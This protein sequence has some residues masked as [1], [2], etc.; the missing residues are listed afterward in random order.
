[1]DVF[2]FISTE[3]HENQSQNLDLDTEKTD[4]LTSSD[5]VPREFSTLS[6]ND[7]DTEKNTINE[8][9]PGCFEGPEKT[10]EVVFRSGFGAEE[11][12][13]CFTKEQL[14]QL[15]Y[16]AKCNIL[17]KISNSHMDAYV[18]SE[19]SLFVYK[20]RFVMKTCGTT[21]LLHCL[22]T[23]L[24]FADRLNMELTWVGYSRKNLLFPSA[25]S[26]PHSSF[27]DEIDYINSHAK[28]QDRLRGAGH[29]LGPITGD[30]WFVYVADHDV[31]FY[32][33]AN[34]L[35]AP[36]PSTERTMN[37]MMFDIHPTVTNIFY[38][39]NTPTAK[40]MTLQSGINTLVPG[41][42]ID[43]A[44]FTPCGYSMNAILHDAYFTIHITPE[45]Q[46]SYASFET[47]NCLSSYDALVRNVLNVFRP[48]RFVLTMFGDEAAM[49]VISKPTDPRK[50]LL[51][52]GGGPPALYSRTSLSCTNVESDLCCLMGVYVLDTSI[53]AR[54]PSVEWI[55]AEQR[56]RGNTLM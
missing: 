29:I 47:N 19:S 36:Q 20:H 37:M 28:L 6:S 54:N 33:S 46:C 34:L 31:P 24:K 14:D 15:C 8:Y 10:L 9:V 45:Q 23:L 49:A 55:S 16:L 27:S 50:I 7:S 44:A 17:S 40:E 35:Q 12:L 3:N 4:S 25:Q 26:W 11:G 56:P 41:A 42:V 2:D 30:H 1:M 53:I 22:K 21:T 18:L 48:K 38:K 5:Y 52:G 13:R 43:E 32:T 39:I 51:P